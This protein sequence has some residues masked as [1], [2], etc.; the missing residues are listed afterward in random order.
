MG[1]GLASLLLLGSAGTAVADDGEATGD[2]DAD[3]D[4]DGDR[5]GPD[6]VDNGEFEACEA[7]FG[8]GKVV[9]VYDDPDFDPDDVDDLDVVAEGEAA[10]D[11]PP[12][13][14][15]P[16]QEW[17]GPW[18]LDEFE[19][20]ITE[21]HGIG[22]LDLDPP[23]D[24][25]YIYSALFEFRSDADYRVDTTWQQDPGAEPLELT[26]AF[27]ACDTGVFDRP[28][29]EEQEQQ[30]QACLETMVNDEIVVFAA[31]EPEPEF[32]PA[33]PEGEVPSAGFVDVISTSV[34]APAID[35]IAWYGI[36][37]GTTATTYEPGGTVTRGQKASFVARMLREA[38]VELPEVDEDAF[39]DI[40][41]STHAEAISQMAELG[42]VEGR[43]AETFLPSSAVTRAQSASMVV[44][45]LDLVLD[46]PLAVPD[47]GPFVDTA[48]STHAEAIDAA[49]QAG[50]VL[51]T[52]PTTFEPNAD[53]RRDQ[54]ASM[55]ARAL[56][57]LAAEGHVQPDED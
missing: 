19:S 53:N 9:V 22:D 56:E 55:L 3:G 4:V 20:D 37:I 41:G 16:W 26:E 39:G 5:V 21:D 12:I 10:P 47:E 6:E 31:P 33:C 43:N 11:C 45:A 32:G 38:G 27:E 40:A 35:C 13:E 14:P 36:T 7:D 8:T 46:D 51:G 23:E 42:V 2:G 49:A 25:P 24:G 29:S 34:H 17:D 52:T 50:I 30:W 54:M 28:T 15:D 18:D 48:G 57:V 44:R 1:T